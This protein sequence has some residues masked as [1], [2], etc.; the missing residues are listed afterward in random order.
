[1]IHIC[2]AFLRGDL[3]V[4]HRELARAWSGALWAEKNSTRV[5]RAIDRLT[6][7]VGVIA[8]T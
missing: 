8:E 3:S 5:C 2:Y 7:E 4:I 6:G 1:M